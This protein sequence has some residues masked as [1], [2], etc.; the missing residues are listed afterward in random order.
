MLNGKKEQVAEW[1]KELSICLHEKSMNVEY[2]IKKK[3]AEVDLIENTVGHKFACE[4]SVYNKDNSR[5]N[6]K[7]LGDGVKLLT[8]KDIDNIDGDTSIGKVQRLRYGKSAI[9]LDARA[10]ARFAR[11][12]NLEFEGV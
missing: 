3:D 12:N 2:H 11:N 1:N 7:Y 5:V 10:L 8:T 9:Y 6:L 4:M